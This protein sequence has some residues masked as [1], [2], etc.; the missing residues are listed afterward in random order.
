[1]QVRPSL[2]NGHE[3]VKTNHAPA[4]V[5][6]SE[7]TLRIV[8][9][10]RKRMLEKD[11]IKLVKRELHHVV[12]QKRKGIS[13]KQKNVT[14]LSVMNDVNTVSRFSKLHDAYTVGQARCLEL[15]AEISKL[16][17]KLQKD[18]HSEMLKHFSKLE[19]DYLNLQLKSQHLKESFGNNKSQTSP[20]KHIEADLIL[21]FKALD[22]RN[23]ELDEHVNALQEQNARF[24]AENKK[25]KQHYKELYDS[26]KITRAKTIE[27]TT[28]LLTENENLKAQLKGKNKMHYYGYCEARIFCPCMSPPIRRKYHDSIAFATGVGGLTKADGV[29]ARFEFPLPWPCRVEEN[30]T[31]KELK[32]NMNGWLIENEEEVERDEVDSDLESTASSKPVW[33]KTTEVEVIK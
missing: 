8:E 28:S 27:M 20:E 19:V 22:S 32:D 5:H 14:L 9:I 21:D 26:I 2:Y 17:H 6:D 3:I 4:V 18:D 10:T 1:M 12:S 29:T 24:R 31:L 11:L 23:K 7:D 15:K 25:V 16:K 30:M 33:E 13:N